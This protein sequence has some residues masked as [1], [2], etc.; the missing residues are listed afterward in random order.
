[1][2][3]DRFGT[4]YLDRVPRIFP[5]VTEPLVTRAWALQERFLSPRLLEYGWRTLLWSC[6]CSERYSGYQPLPALNESNGDALPA[7][8][9][10][11]FGYLNPSGIRRIPQR[12]DEIFDYWVGI[13]NQY[14][15]CNLTFPDDRLA[16]IGGVAAEI[17][18]RT[19]VPYL[20][21]LWDYERLP[22]LLLWRVDSPLS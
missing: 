7:P 16:A 20:A 14:T 22:S 9:Y 19:G 18:E 4:I 11:L 15:R 21:G 6:S 10:S 12:R 2:P 5:S 17:Q 3:N 13:V 8:S 1:M